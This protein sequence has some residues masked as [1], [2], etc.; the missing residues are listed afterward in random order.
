MSL[1]VVPVA[2]RPECAR[3]LHTAFDLGARLGA[4]VKGCHIRPHRYSDLSVGSEF[5]EAAWRRKSTKRAPVAAKALY[6]DIAAQHGYKLMRR[7]GESPRALWVERVG[8]PAKIMGI[9]GPMSDMI[10]VSRPGNSNGVATMFL[11]SALYHAGRPLLV[12]PQRSRRRIGRHICIAW[13]QGPLI[14]RVVTASIPVLQQADTVTIITCG[15][16]DRP[17]PKASLLRQYLASW[18]VD[19]GHVRTRGRYVERELMEAFKKEGGD[20]LL[21]GAYTHRRWYEKVLGGTTEFLI[22][23][24]RM[25]V[26]MQ[27][28]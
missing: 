24:A 11:K 9:T 6:E 10:V 2:D 16:D 14:S 28:V 26:L 19:A 25:P 17:G 7:A 21:A 20:L 18:G 23:K 27:H 15:P 5:A 8:S 12:L 3:A 22:H 13:D 4:S 1:I